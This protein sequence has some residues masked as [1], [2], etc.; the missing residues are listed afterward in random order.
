MK[1]YRREHPEFALCG[2]NCRLCPMHLGNY[3]PGCGGGEGHQS[4]A[5]IRCSQEQGDVEQ[6]FQCAQFPCGRYGSAMEYDSF[7]PHSGMVRNQELARDMGLERYLSQL[8][9]RRAILDR[10]LAGWNDGRR[11]GFYCLAVDLLEPE[12]LYEAMEQ[13]DAALPE[14]APMK[15]KAAAAVRVFQAAAQRRGVVLKLNKKP[16]ERK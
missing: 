3:C 12:D 7:L 13:L 16:K 10:L 8:E 15:E 14:D 2:L 9:E 4:C 6:C 1:N 5:F 11:K